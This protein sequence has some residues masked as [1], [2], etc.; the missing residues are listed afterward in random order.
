MKEA[1]PEVLRTIDA[2]EKLLQVN[3]EK[4]DKIQGD[5]AECGLTLKVL[6]ADI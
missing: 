4:I 5:I 6:L 3:A 1:S 2:V